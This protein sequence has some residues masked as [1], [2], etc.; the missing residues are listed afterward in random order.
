MI[1]P[2]APRKQT[3][4]T[5]ESP[6]SPSSSL[7][8]KQDDSDDSAGELSSARVSRTPTAANDWLRQTQASKPAARGNGHRLHATPATKG[9]RPGSRT[10]Q[11]ESFGHRPT[12]WF[13][14]NVQHRPPSLRCRS[15]TVT[16]IACKVK[17]FGGLIIALDHA[18]HGQAEAGGHWTEKV[19]RIT[20]R[21]PSS[22]WVESGLGRK[23]G[24]CEVEGN[25]GQP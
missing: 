19:L 2:A 16:T 14:P 13:S 21:C 17:V 6:A 23:S 15:F 11:P 24:L 4:R 20:Q 22:G 5:S 9:C 12:R 10:S 25:L 8:S 18:R 3:A 1:S 7:A